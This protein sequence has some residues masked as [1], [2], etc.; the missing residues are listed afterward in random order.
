MGQRIVCLAGES[1]EFKVVAALEHEGHASLGDDIGTV[2]GVG[3]AGVAVSDRLTVDCAVMIDFSVAAGSVKWAEFCGEKRVPLVIGSTGMSFKQRQIIAAAAE[4]TAI[5]V[6]SNMS[7]GVNLLFKLAGE[8]AKVLDEEYDV[9]IVEKH[10]RFKRDAPSGTALELARRIAVEK[11]WDFPGRLEHGR[12][13]GEALRQAKTIGM[14]AVR[15]GDTIGEHQVLFTT[16][17]ETL[18]LRHQAH[19]RDTF[20]RGALKAAKWLVGK[21]AGLYEMANVLGL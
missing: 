20:V 2:S 9:E 6:G 14:H 8:V 3:E 7:M 13:G 12:E 21:K 4:K 18:E 19:S 11:G 17:G 1:V 15:A 16:L 5:L 10:H